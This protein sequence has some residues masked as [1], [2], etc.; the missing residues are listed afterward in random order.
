MKT[1]HPDVSGGGIRHEGSGPN[2]HVKRTA[3]IERPGPVLIRR[4]SSGEWVKAE[5]T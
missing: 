5:Y 2:R 4:A 1:N 3:R